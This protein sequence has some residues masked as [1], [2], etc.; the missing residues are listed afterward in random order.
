[1]LKKILCSV[2]LAAWG[3]AVLWPCQAAAPAKI[4]TV[5]PAADLVA[6][7]EAKIKALEEALATDQSYLGA[8]NTTIPTEA[9]VLAVLAQALAESEEASPL[10]GA[11]ADLREGAIAVAGSKSY[12]EA[13]KG[14][15][16]IKEAQGGKSA[17]A[18]AEAEWNKLCKLGALMKEVN[19]RN[20]KLRRETRN[21]TNAEQAARDASV[22]AVLALAA[23]D[24]T[25]EVKKPEQV[26]EW[27]KFAKE[28]QVQMTAAAAA[29]KKNDKA[30]AADAFK[31]GNTACNDCH[32]KFRENE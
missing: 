14:L 23:H 9:G 6:E 4:A 21:L 8:K 18:K 20:G 28:Y 10:K 13:K 27:Q 5:A 11:A 26:A 22:L 25:H 19:K 17:G 12:D 7:A 1:M 2:S 31:K 30:A 24:D 16:A 29:F 15:A 32:A 3:L